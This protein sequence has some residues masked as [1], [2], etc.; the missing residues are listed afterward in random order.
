[1]AACDQFTGLVCRDHIAETLIAGI[2]D[3]GHQFLFLQAPD[4]ADACRMGDLQ[5]FSQ[6]L[7]RDLMVFTDQKIMQD[8]DLRECHVR[9]FHDI[10]DLLFEQ[11]IDFFEF[12]AQR[13]LLYIMAA[14]PHTILLSDPISVFICSMLHMANQSYSHKDPMSIREQGFFLYM[15]V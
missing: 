2:D 14:E 3:T 9:F 10:I 15:G 7:Q 8:S 12:I 5:G 11:F 13:L 6:L 1:M 4:Q